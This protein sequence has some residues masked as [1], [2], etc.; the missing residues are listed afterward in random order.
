VAISAGSCL[1]TII[2]PYNYSLLLLE[3]SLQGAAA[4][5]YSIAA[6]VLLAEKF[7]VAWVMQAVAFMT[8]GEAHPCKQTEQGS[9]M[10]DH[11]FW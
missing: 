9:H 1:L 10:T 6:M 11:G 3:R 7:P 8:A 4:A 2:Q 5:A